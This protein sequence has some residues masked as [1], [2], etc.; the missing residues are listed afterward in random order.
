MGGA[1]VA[2][3]LPALDAMMNLEGTA[4]ADGAGTPKRFVLWFWGNGTVPGDWAPTTQGRDWTP[5]PLMRGLGAAVDSV[6]MVSGT[7]LPV[8]GVNNPHVEGVCGVLSGGNPLLDASFTGSGGD[9]NFMT[10]PA[11]S[12][13]VLAA[14]VLGTP[15]FRSMVLGITTPHGSSGPGTAVSYV[16]HNGPYDPNPPEL[17]PAA[18]FAR[19]F[20][21]GLPAAGVD[22]PSA[23]ELARASVLDAVLEDAAS[24]ESRLGASDRMRLDQ[25][26]TTI[27]DMERRLRSTTTGMLGESCLERSAPDVVASFR[28]RSQVMNELIALAF[29]CDLTRV[30][31]MQFSSPASH[32]GYPDVFPGGIQHNGAPTSFH[33]Y[34]HSN[35]FDETVRTGLQYLGDAFGDHLATMEATSECGET[36][37][38]HSVVLGTSE[39]SNGWQHRFD[40]FPFVVA[41]KAGG[42]LDAGQHVRLEGALP[43]RVPLTILRALGSDVASFGQEQFETSEVITELLT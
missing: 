24:L 26:L 28:E 20:G 34:E 32:S 5:T 40:D 18:V 17:D 15:S 21:G 23:E 35:G 41:G 29:A 16:S 9:W 43:G 33:E 42:A 39:L 10:T 11:P 27:R 30:A 25:H 14:D 7:E 3:G 13:D 19:F 38:D 1:S 2:I 22:E 12:I 36:M 6:S 37:L 8:R 4:F 31:V